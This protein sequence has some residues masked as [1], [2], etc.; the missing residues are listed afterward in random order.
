MKRSNAFLI[1]YVVFVLFVTPMLTLAG[2]LFSHIGQLT[3]GTLVVGLTIG[4][5]AKLVSRRLS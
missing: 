1:M 3:S 2:H 5:I 4:L